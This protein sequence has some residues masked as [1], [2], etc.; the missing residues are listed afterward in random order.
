MSKNI[1]KEYYPI[2]HRNCVESARWLRSGKEY[3]DC[4]KH[5]N[6]PPLSPE[7]R[8][9]LAKKYDKKAAD[10]LNPDYTGS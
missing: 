4:L 10:Y 6:I 3:E 7:D 9:I 5:M 2:W 8:E 1:L